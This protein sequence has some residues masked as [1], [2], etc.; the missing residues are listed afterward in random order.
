M[1]NFTINKLIEK[2][3]IGIKH[4]KYPRYCYRRKIEKFLKQF[5]TMSKR[6]RNEKGLSQLEAALSIGQNHLDFM[7]ILKL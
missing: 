5:L 1:K 7:Q 2:F 6:I 3:S 4:D